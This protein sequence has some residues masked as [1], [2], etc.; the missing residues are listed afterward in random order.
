MNTLVD[1]LE[2]A[3]R[4]YPDRTAVSLEV[5]LRADDWSY[6]RLWQASLA[7]AAHLRQDL[8]LERGA[9]VLIWEPNSPRL[10]ATAFGCMLA[11]ITLVPLDLG[12]SDDFVIRLAE[13]T[14]ASA[15]LTQF[16]ARR[17]FGD[18]RVIPM[19]QLPFERDAPPWTERPT[20]A[21]LVEVVFTSGTT[22]HP[23]GVELTHAN[24][25]AN[26]HGVSGVIPHGPHYRLLSLLPLSHMLE[27]TAGLYLPL[28]YGASIHYL[29]T[30][31]PSA[32]FKAL[33]RRRIIGMV[34]VPAVLEVLMRGIEREVRRQGRWEQ[35]QRLQMVAE[36]LPL[37][38]RRLLFARVHRELGGSLDF[39]L[40]GGAYLSP[41]L[42]RSW[43]R[44]GVKVV[45]GYGA[46]ECAPVVSSNTLADRQHGSIGMPV[47]GVQ[48]RLSA[49]GELLVHGPNVTRGYWRDEQATR[50]AFTDDGWY[51]SG[52]LAEQNPNGRLTL[53]GRLRDLIVLANGLNV[54]PED[55]E[56]ELRGEP[57][58]ADCVALGLADAEGNRRVH[59][60]VRP[61]EAERLAEATRAEVEAAVR[62]ANARLAPHQRIADISLWPG[63]D[64]PRTSSL[65]IKRQEVQRF[66]EGAASA[67]TP[68]AP[69]PAAQ[70]TLGRLR[71]VL[72]L[73]SKT[74]PHAIQPDTDLARDLGIDSLGR[75]ELAVRLE[76]E[77][78][79]PLDETRLATVP[80]VSD[81]LAL[82]EQG[83]VTQPRL[84]LPRWS[85]EPPAR[86]TRRFVQEALLFAGHRIAC[87]PFRVEGHERLRT[88]RLPA[89]FIANHTSHLDT[90][91]V[92]RALPGPIRQRLAVAAAADYFY[93]DARLGFASSLALN[94]F[95]FSREGAVRASLEYCGELIDRG[96]SILIYPEGTRSPDGALQP[97]KS[98]I[99]LLAREMAIPIVPVGLI[100]LHQV[101]PK[102]RTRP[103]P[104]AV[105]VRFGAPL[106]IPT[107]TDNLEAAQLLHDALAALIAVAVAMRPADPG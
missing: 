60:V 20:G 55:V 51:R 22:G 27:Q 31:Q 57:I 71:T 89:I 41:S 50:L 68:D 73:V 10:V 107:T 19:H 59:A 21:D 24:I 87:Q 30:R 32:I 40:C 81:V 54:Y 16:A 102:G 35:W 83:A 75:V 94:T 18:L 103:Q 106:I 7:V 15:L 67:A 1:L 98:G 96:W 90:L 56:Q 39:F 3:A 66:V 46:T 8:G 74:P 14:Q 37:P 47:R 9:R 80:R 29:P 97:F 95:P 64:F 6:Q 79:F 36:R 91:T 86:I 99:G 12:S 65:K 58:V 101:L 84:P 92:L 70:D 61:R 105:L 72:A 88:L 69:A 13:L 49:E 78:G 42:A 28:R 4:R 52:D 33:Q 11:G 53:K 93:R 26:V 23:K 44:L 62:A 45:Q 76:E 63:D 82:I 17:S 34:V 48:V 85:V 43:E 25:V 100:G 2:Q 77:L 5:G 104:G 38:A